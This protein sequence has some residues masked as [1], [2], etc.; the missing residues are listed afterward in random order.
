MQK[1]QKHFTESLK[2]IDCQVVELERQIEMWQ[3]VNEDGSKLAE[4]PGIDPLTASAIVATVGRAKEFKSCRPVSFM[5]GIGAQTTF[6]WRQ[7]EFVGQQQTRR[8]LS[9]NTANQWSKSGD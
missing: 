2:E 3:R 5:D 1:L 9:Q 4:I 6:Q 7:T 8:Y